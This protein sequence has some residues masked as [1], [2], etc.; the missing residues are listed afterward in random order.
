MR[1]T[2]GRS[3]GQYTGGSVVMTTGESVYTSSGAFLITTANA[4]PAGTSGDISVGTGL[5]QGYSGAISLTTGEAL[6]GSGG[7]IDLL[8][9]D[10]AL[11][12]GG[13]ISL[14]AGRSSAAGARGGAVSLV[15]GDGTRGRAKQHDGVAVQASHQGFAA[16]LVGPGEHVPGVV[17]AGWSGR[18]QGDLRA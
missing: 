2:G 4:G 13:A 6:G 1:I 16:H 11:G 17:D 7:A 5:S 14:R 15:G 18:V 8:V 9:G 10:G 3:T 12:D